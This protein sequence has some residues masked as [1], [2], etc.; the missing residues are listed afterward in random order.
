MLQA[1]DAEKEKPWEHVGTFNNLH[2][3]TWKYVGVVKVDNW[4][5]FC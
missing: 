2:N 5:G 1:S 3:A 4:E